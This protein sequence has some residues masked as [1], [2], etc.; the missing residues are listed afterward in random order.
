MRNCGIVVTALFII[1]INAAPLGVHAQ[2]IEE[3]IV[4]AQKREQNQ[5]DVSISVNSFWAITTIS[6]MT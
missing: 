2:V 5:Q 1:V 6:S 3:I 4:I